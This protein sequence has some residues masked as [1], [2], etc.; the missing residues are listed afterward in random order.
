MRVFVLFR[1]IQRL[2]NLRQRYVTANGRATPAEAAYQQT[3]LLLN[4]AVQVR[5]AAFRRAVGQMVR[6]LAPGETISR[7]TIVAEADATPRES[8]ALEWVLTKAPWTRTRRSQSDRG[9]YGRPQDPFT[10]LSRARERGVLLTTG[11]LMWAGR[12]AAEAWRLTH[13]NADPARMTEEGP[14]GIH[15]VFCYP[16]TNDY[17]AIVDQAID[18]EDRGESRRGL[19]PRREGR[20]QAPRRERRYG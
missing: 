8:E 19:G 14:Q 17:L 20:G 18:A 3:L 2:G 11:Q 13:G 1:R 9:H 5:L 7:V 10:V 12:R 15:D 6:H 16:R 4:G